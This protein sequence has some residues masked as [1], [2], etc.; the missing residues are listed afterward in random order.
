MCPT[1]LPCFAVLALFLSEKTVH[2]RDVTGFGNTGVLYLYSHDVFLQ[3]HLLST[4][5]V[6]VSTCMTELSNLTE[7]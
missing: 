6:L 4:Y 5:K 2:D 1:S 7:Y 3:Q